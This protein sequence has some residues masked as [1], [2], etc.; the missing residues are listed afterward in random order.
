VTNVLRAFILSAWL[1]MPV[2]ALAF[3]ILFGLP[4]RY[5]DRAMAWHLVLTTLIAGLE[6][7]GFLLSGL[8]L[9]PAAIIYVGSL[10]VMVWRLILLI[11]TRRCSKRRKPK[12]NFLV[13]IVPA[14]WRKLAYGL[15]ALV[16]F[17]VTVWQTA[18]G[19]WKTALISLV[20]SAATAVAHA[21]TNATPAETIDG[22]PSTAK[23]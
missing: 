13:D 9:W 1:I 21:N 22:D 11:Q 18:D 12:M 19:D 8:S 6:P 23:P 5:R 4:V 7:V 15:L 20:T 3:L 14:K 10:S 17:A 2:L 16:A